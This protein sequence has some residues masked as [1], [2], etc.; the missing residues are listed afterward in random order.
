[1]TRC[2]F[3]NCEEQAVAMVHITG[4]GLRAVCATHRAWMDE[5]G[6]AYRADGPLA[7]RLAAAQPAPAAEPFVPS[8]RRHLTAVDRTGALGR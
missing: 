1:M 7:R 8:W 4:V 3:P 2:R 6:F 5:I